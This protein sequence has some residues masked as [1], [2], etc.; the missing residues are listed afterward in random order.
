[1]WE[2]AWWGRL[3][4][5]L[6][7]ILLTARLP[8]AHN[9]FGSM[10]PVV[11]SIAPVLC[12]VALHLRGSTNDMPAMKGCAASMTLPASMGGNTCSS[13]NE[14]GRRRMERVREGVC[15]GAERPTPLL[16]EGA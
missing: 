9:P 7:M 10:Q 14:W 11:K 16:F 4:T 15:A 3:S 6:G 13:Q 5:S 12:A 1:V 2:L 8:A